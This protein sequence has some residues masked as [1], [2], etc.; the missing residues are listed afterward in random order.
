[1]HFLFKFFFQ[2]NSIRGCS[3]E[4]WMNL[5]SAFDSGLMNPPSLLLA[6][7]NSK[8]LNHKRIA[9]FPWCIK[10]SFECT[11]MI[12]PCRLPSQK[13]N[14]HWVPINSAGDYFITLLVES[15]TSYF[16]LQNFTSQ[17]RNKRW[18]GAKKKRL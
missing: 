4:T 13:K 12:F 8:R 3:Y 6:M 18:H 9:L 14:A 2:L 11:F 1:M 17:L 7:K 5:E 10:C 15:F 16:V